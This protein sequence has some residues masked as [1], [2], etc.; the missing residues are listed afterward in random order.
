[1]KIKATG[2]YKGRLMTVEVTD[3]YGGI[4]YLFNGKPDAVMKYEILDRI[5]D[6]VLIGG[7]Y[8]PETDALRIYAALEGYFF[9]RNPDI[10]AEGITEEIPLP[11]GD[12]GVY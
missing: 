2:K 3:E 6:G 10:T 12:G 4:L 9:D 5:E 11:D 8:I 7:T 1:M